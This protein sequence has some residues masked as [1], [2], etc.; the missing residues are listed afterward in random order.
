MGKI[1]PQFIVCGGWIFSQHDEDEHKISAVILSGLY[2]LKK[3]ERILIAGGDENLKR[4]K[5]RYPQ[6]IIL[7]PRYDGKYDRRESC[8]IRHEKA[9]P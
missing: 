1:K 2:H 7:G 6:A 8:N 4:M 3:H 9:T 5:R